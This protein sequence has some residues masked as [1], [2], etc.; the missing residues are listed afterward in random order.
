[1]DLSKSYRTNDTRKLSVNLCTSGQICHVIVFN[2]VVCKS[3]EA[4]S[5]LIF[6]P[7]KLAPTNIALSRVRWQAIFSLFAK[8]ISPMDKC[9]NSEAEVIILQIVCS[10][11]SKP[12]STAY[13][14]YS[15]HQ[16]R[17]NLS[18][19]TCEEIIAHINIVF[20]WLGLNEN[21]LI[22]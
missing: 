3:K 8:A 19:N 4:R 18:S 11:I 2:Y 21:H 15:F 14:S 6:Q 10:N 20:I 9:Y 17:K 7:A 16:L 22:G 13:R 12:L 1:M 5:Q